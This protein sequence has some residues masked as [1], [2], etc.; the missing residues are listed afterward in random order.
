MLDFPEHKPLK[1]L[2]NTLC[3]DTPRD[4]RETKFSWVSES[5]DINSFSFTWGDL[6]IWAHW[7]FPVQE[8][9]VTKGMTL[10]YTSLFFFF[11]P[12]NEFSWNSLLLSTF[13][14]SFYYSSLLPWKLTTWPDHKRWLELSVVKANIC[15]PKSLQCSQRNEFCHW[16]QWE[17][18]GLTGQADVSSAG[19]IFQLASAAA[20]IFSCD[21]Y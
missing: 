5:E 10:W 15:I 17:V 16:L 9:S 21:D 6:R 19:N 14:P 1:E 20:S 8:L 18:W 12:K 3:K 13:D 4:L 11:R 7:L 2:V